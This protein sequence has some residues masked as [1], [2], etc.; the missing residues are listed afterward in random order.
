MTQ[1]EIM[2]K[3]ADLPA[4]AEPMAGYTLSDGTRLEFTLD[5]WREIYAWLSLG[6][7]K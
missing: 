5:Q 1:V 7:C 4:D 2:I 6:K 3:E